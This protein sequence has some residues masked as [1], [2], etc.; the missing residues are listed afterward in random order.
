MVARYKNPD[1]DSRGPWLLSDLA[2]RNFYAQGRYPITTSS[3]RVIEGPPAGSYWRVSKEKFD[4]LAKDNRIWFGNGD[5]RPGI[6]R[7]LS[8][9]KEGI[10]PQ[11]IWSWKD[12]GSTRNAKQEISEIMSA[13]ANEDLFI[14]P[15][16]S[17]LI[18]RILRIA[19]DKDSII[20]DSFA[21]SGTT[22]QAVLQL[23]KEDGGN[24]KFVLIEME[25]YADK[26]TAER[27]RRVI[28]G[29]PA[30]K[31]EALKNAKL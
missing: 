14:T 27:V 18:E 19:T 1:N 4:D 17:K 13:G 29:V 15:K 16:P 2:A 26:L 20:L 9:V 25:G 12:A 30:S 6:K 24:R 7:F 3:G 28:K 10:V 21:G 5:V 11:T 8:E 22:A 23:N 31:N